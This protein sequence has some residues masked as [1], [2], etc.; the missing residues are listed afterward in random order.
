V[1]IVCPP[2]VTVELLTKK[3]WTR[4]L[5]QKVQLIYPNWNKAFT[6][7]GA[8]QSAPLKGKEKSYLSPL[9]SRKVQF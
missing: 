9:F 8:L 2:K 3:S 7:F 4:A 1:L 5:L 6:N